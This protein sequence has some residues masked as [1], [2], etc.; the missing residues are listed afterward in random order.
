MNIFFVRIKKGFP[1]VSGNV[2]TALSHPKLVVM[3]SYSRCT[4]NPD[5][6]LQLFFREAEKR[7][8]M[9]IIESKS[10]SQQI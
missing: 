7:R 4:L 10:I 8:C 1:N 3:Y 2:W 6:H 9:K 5:V